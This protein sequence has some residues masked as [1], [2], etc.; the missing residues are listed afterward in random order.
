ME[1][2]RPAGV[3]L[4]GGRSRRLGTDKA[5]VRLGGRTLLEH[6]ASA[7]GSLCAPLIIAGRVPATA[8]D[9]GVIW[10]ADLRPGAGPLAGLEAGLAVAPQGW[11]AAA[12]CDQPF[13]RP[14]LLALLWSRARRSTAG[15]VI[16]V[17]GGQPQPFPGL[18]HTCL[19]P[20]VAR[21][22]E[23]GPAPVRALFDLIAVETVDEAEIRT[24]DPDLRSFHNVNTPEA[25]REALALG[26]PG[27]ERCP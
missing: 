18:Y 9:Q 21:V 5:L 19:R 24:V 25:Y 10:A 16:P 12:A 27:K 23:A 7:L 3:I 17:V 22:L 4:A 8:V 6:A 26:P 2:P 15:A 20:L 11:V 14:A 13:L 1:G